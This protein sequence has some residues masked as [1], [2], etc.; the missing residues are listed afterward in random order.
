MTL[1]PVL[2]GLMMAFPQVQT[3]SYKVDVRLYMIPAYQSVTSGRVAADGTTVGTVQGGDVTS[4]FPDHPVFLRTDQ[5]AGPGTSMEIQELQEFLY[6][7]KV[8]SP[9]PCL[10]QG[11]K[12]DLV[13][14]YSLSWPPASPVEEPAE[15]VIVTPTDNSPVCRLKVSP[16]SIDGIDAAIGLKLTGFD[17]VLFD[18]DVQ[19][20]LDD[21]TI[22]GFPRY[23]EEAGTPGPRTPVYI[24]VLCVHKTG[25]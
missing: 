23:Q 10:P 2:C 1:L 25:A 8:L 14:E 13:E 17:R 11:V 3:E 15:E 9:M 12:W 4:D 16:R 20:S 5:P 24:L 22:V 6:A 7:R 21:K 19:V 18:Q